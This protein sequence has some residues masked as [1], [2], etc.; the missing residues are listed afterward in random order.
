MINGNM[1]AIFTIF[2]TTL[3]VHNTNGNIVLT[4]PENDGFVI[5]KTKLKTYV[6]RY[7]CNNFS[8]SFIFVELSK[9]KGERE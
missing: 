8:N 2:P 4:L 7:S 9:D 6:L 5:D 3:S 1:D